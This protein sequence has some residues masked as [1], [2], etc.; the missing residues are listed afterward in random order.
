MQDIKEIFWSNV[1]WHR[2]NKG[3]KWTDLVQGSAPSAKNKTA[4]IT[5]N[6]VQKIAEDLGISDYAILFESWDE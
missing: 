1:N 4:N 3:L 6:K 2:E 5:L